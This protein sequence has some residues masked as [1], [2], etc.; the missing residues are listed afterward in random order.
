MK[1]N[2][3]IFLLF[4]VFILL[5][6]TFTSIQTNGYTLSGN[7]ISFNNNNV[8]FSIN[9]H[10]TQSTTDIFSI[11]ND[12]SNFYLTLSTASKYSYYLNTQSKGSV[13][14]SSVIKNYDQI[15]AKNFFISNNTEFIAVSSYFN[16]NYSFTIKD[17]Q[18]NQ[19]LSESGI[20]PYAISLVTSFNN[21]SDVFFIFYNETMF[22]IAMYNFQLN[23]F[24]IFSHSK[25]LF[26]NKYYLSNVDVFTID[27]KLY[28]SYVI[29]DNSSSP[30]TY[31]STVLIS[32]SGKMLFNKTFNDFDLGFFTPT[33]SGFILQSSQNSEFY[34]YHISSDSILNTGQILNGISALKPYNNNSFMLLTS[35][36]LYQFAINS[37]LNI[38]HL[39]IVNTYDLVNNIF[40]NELFS[41]NLDSGKFYILGMQNQSIEYTI[42]KNNYGQGPISP[43]SL[44]SSTVLNPSSSS[45]AASTTPPPT[46]PSVTYSYQSQ[47]TS[48]LQSIFT[49]DPTGVILIFILFIIGFIGVII[50]SNR[51]RKKEQDYNS[52]NQSTNNI[53]NHQN[54]WENKNQYRR[55]NNFCIECGSPVEPNDVFCQNCGK[56]I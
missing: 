38:N 2:K 18:T 43:P 37:S 25:N 29:T 40:Y 47:S 46:A 49:P 52:R 9:P 41:Y 33:T 35:N 13:P 17:L 42:S 54:I 24:S 6:F 53:Y 31:N 27:D 51:Q 11:Y 19:T 39:T 55:I 12:F 26:Y 30:I 15:L 20:T 22:N 3:K 8:S 23:Q 28:S 56:R 32:N 36:K 44:P 45:G 21:S 48:T 5:N 34:D 4:A 10:Y 16:G 14:I 1:K 50:Y 7:S